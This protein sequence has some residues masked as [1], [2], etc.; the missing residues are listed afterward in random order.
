MYN[1]CIICIICSYV[2]SVCI[3]I[4]MYNVRSLT[5]CVY[6]LCHWRKLQVKTLMLTSYRTWPPTHCA[7]LVLLTGKPHPLYYNLVFMSSFKYLV[8]SFLL[9]KDLFFH[10]PL[11]FA[12]SW[13]PRNIAPPPLE[14]ICYR[15]LYKN[16][17]NCFP[18]TTPPTLTRP[19]TLTSWR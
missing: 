14:F 15:L 16:I 17:C 13:I 5:V 9:H 10:G 19:R 12:K 11:I 7:P 8:H 1:V 3:I 2:H 6:R 4:V 18:G